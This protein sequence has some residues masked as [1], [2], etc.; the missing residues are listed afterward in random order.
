MY[1]ISFFNIRDNNNFKKIHM[2]ISWLFLT[3]AI[4]YDNVVIITTKQKNLYVRGWMKN[5]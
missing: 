4:E 2:V 5:A 3:I 1:T